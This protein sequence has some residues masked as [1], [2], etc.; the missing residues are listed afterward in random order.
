[1]RSNLDGS[2][3]IVKIYIIYQQFPRNKVAGPKTWNYPSKTKKKAFRTGV[4]VWD[5]CIAS[6]VMMCQSG[7]SGIITLLIHANPLV[8]RENTITTSIYNIQYH[9]TSL[10]ILQQYFQK[11]T[12]LM[13]LLLHFSISLSFIS[14]SLDNIPG[15][16]WSSRC[17]RASIKVSSLAVSP[18]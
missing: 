4:L 12:L 13:S 5:N 3:L 11:L 1:M 6:T 14:S 15:P 18:S 7:Q 17:Q 10:Q 2:R 9:E 16:T 8:T